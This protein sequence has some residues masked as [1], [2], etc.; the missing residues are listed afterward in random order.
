MIELLSG[1][2][3]DIFVFSKALRE[4]QHPPVPVALTETEGMTVVFRTS[5]LLLQYSLSGN[6]RGPIV[7][8]KL[9][10]SPSDVGSEDSQFT[11][12]SMYMDRDA[13]V[14]ISLEADNPS[15]L[16]A[17]RYAEHEG[18]KQMWSPFSTASICEQAG[19][20]IGLVVTEASC[21]AAAKSAEDINGKIGIS[22]Q[23]SGISTKTPCSPQVASFHKRHFSAMIYFDFQRSPAGELFQGN[24][25]VPET[26]S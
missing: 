25:T 5:P 6:G 18:P 10:W 11:N 22:L 23:D 14:N 1:F 24:A 9:Y 7:G 16:H 8:A 17:V 13:I 4:A 2:G 26:S 15:K 12:L 19:T 20:T 3:R 21:I